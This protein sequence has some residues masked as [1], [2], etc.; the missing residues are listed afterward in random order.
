[1]PSEILENISLYCVISLAYS[2]VI[3]H[4]PLINNLITHGLVIYALFF[5]LGITQSHNLD[6]R[7]FSAPTLLPGPG[8]CWPNSLVHVLGSLAQGYELPPFIVSFRYLNHFL[9]NFF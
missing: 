2:R 6:C 5:D 9:C 4:G 3:L 8:G 1:M 7:D